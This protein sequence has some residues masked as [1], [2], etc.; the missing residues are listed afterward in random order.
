MSEPSSAPFDAAYAMGDITKEK[1]LTGRRLSRRARV[2][3]IA[4][5]VL[6]V[7]A[8]VV[9]L[10]LLNRN[11]KDS[12]QSQHRSQQSGSSYAPQDPDS[13]SARLTLNYL[14]SSEGAQILHMHRTAAGLFRL[15]SA[16][17]CR[18][19]VADLDQNAPPGPLAMII[20]RVPDAELRD[21]LLAERLSVSD[22]LTACIEGQA[23]SGGQVHPLA[24]IV[25]FVQQRL[26]ALEA[27]K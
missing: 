26:S 10:I 11:E 15:P 23:P 5:I 20:G 19:V 8:T 16:D 3:T 21:A 7:F 1:V 17:E 12:V 18:R 22:T 27:A 13:E 6:I 2:L 14:S 25:A 9:V 4:G 24:D